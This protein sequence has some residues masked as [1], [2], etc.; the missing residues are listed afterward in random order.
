MREGKKM[1]DL[2]HPFQLTSKLVQ[3]RTSDLNCILF[4][5]FEAPKPKDWLTSDSGVCLEANAAP[6]HAAAAAPRQAPKGRRPAVWLLCSLWRMYDQFPR[7]T[8]PNR[9]NAIRGRWSWPVSKNNCLASNLNSL[10][11]FDVL[12]Q[13]MLKNQHRLAKGFKASAIQAR[14][15]W[16]AVC[17]ISDC[18]SDI[19]LFVRYRAGAYFQETL[20]WTPARYQTEFLQWFEGQPS[21]HRSLASV[22]PRECFLTKE[23]SCTTS[24][25]VWPRDM[26]RWKHIMLAPCHVA[27]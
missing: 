5:H 6:F 22:W 25:N 26:A 15:R 14:L 1:F 24:R 16:L 27:W 13:M 4:G 18:L 19:G 21:S 2:L 9:S 3:D 12:Y 11:D 10:F 20:K 23:C 17:R 7:T 8:A